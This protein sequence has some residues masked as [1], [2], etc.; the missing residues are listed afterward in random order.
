MMLGVTGRPHGADQFVESLICCVQALLKDDLTR[1]DA[2]EV[3]RQCAS[4]IAG[5]ALADVLAVVLAF[6]GGLKQVGDVTSPA[7]WRAQI[8]VFSV[9]IGISGRYDQLVICNGLL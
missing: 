7:I 1:F 6:E 2:L 9:G 3:Q 8:E 5:K 4:K